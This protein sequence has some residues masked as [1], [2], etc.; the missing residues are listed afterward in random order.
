MKPPIDLRTLTAVVLILAFAHAGLGR[1]LPFDTSSGVTF[2][3]QVALFA[4]YLY[5]MRTLIRLPFAVAITLRRTRYA[6]QQYKLSG[7]ESLRDG[8]T[9]GFLDNRRWSVEPLAL[10]DR[11]MICTATLLV[12]IPG[13]G[14]LLVTLG[15]FLGMA[16]LLVLYLMRGSFGWL[17][18]DQLESPVQSSIQLPFINRRD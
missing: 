18:A 15:G 10:V 3:S 1:E 7:I 16:L 12:T 11:V 6:R 14:G 13:L 5:V 2:I 4:S 17:V 9:R 8:Y